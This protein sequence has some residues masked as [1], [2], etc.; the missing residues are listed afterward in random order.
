MAHDHVGHAASGDGAAKQ[1]G[2]P[3][4][5]PAQ[6]RLGNAVAVFADHQIADD[7]VLALVHHGVPLEAVQVDAPVAD[8]AS[9]QAEMREE[10]ERSFTGPG[11]PPVTREMVRGAGFA[12]V[13]GAVIAAVLAAPFAIIDFGPVWWVRL[14]IVCL[15]GMVGGGTI[16]F[17]AGGGIMAKGPASAAAAQRGVVVSVEGPNPDVIEFLKRRRPIR[18]DLVSPAGAPLGTVVTEDDYTRKGMTQRVG[19]RLQQDP[20]AGNEWATASRDETSTAHDR[21]A[22]RSREER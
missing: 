10:T 6:P 21:R 20:G 1:S 14:I 9:L 17:I 2:V 5:D 22:T 15:I 11:F 8:V 19:E 13:I 16:G 18:L 4:P 12:V 7:V 3:Q